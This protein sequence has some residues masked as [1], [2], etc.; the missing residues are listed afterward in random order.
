MN[1]DCNFYLPLWAFLI[2][3]IFETPLQIIGELK[4]DYQFLIVIVINF[5]V[6]LTFLLIYRK[7]LFILKRE[8][9]NKFS[10]IFGYDVRVHQI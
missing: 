6:Q 8:I 4:E 1:M 3:S 7:I 9:D 2:Y 10:N 5:L